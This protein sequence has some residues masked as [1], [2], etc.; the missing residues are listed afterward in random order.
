MRTADTP[1]PG[2]RTLGK[3]EAQTDRAMRFTYYGHQVWIPKRAIVKTP[4]GYCAPAWAIDSS[5]EYQ[6]QRRVG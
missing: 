5:K 6:S 2:H 1:P 4:Q 3:L